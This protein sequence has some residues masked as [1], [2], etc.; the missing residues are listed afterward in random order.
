MFWYGKGD[1]GKH[2]FCF[3]FFLREE[4]SRAVSYYLHSQCWF[5]PTR[6]SF[7]WSV[8]NWKHWRFWRKRAPLCT[9]FCP[10]LCE[11]ASHWLGTS[12]VLALPFLGSRVKRLTPIE[13]PAWRGSTWESSPKSLPTL[14]PDTPLCMEMPGRNSNLN[15]IWV[16]LV[17]NP[18]R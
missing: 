6:P 2:S 10:A 14:R 13:E 17:L 9:G 1:S 4:T 11:N 15:W 8:R 16:P 7:G 12:G 5:L 3:Q 18:E